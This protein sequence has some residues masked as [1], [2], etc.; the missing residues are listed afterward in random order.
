MNYAD[1]DTPFTRIHEPKHLHLERPWNRK[2]TVIM[3]EYSCV[4]PERPYYPV[5]FSSDREIYDKYAE[6]QREQPNVIFGGRLARYKYYDMHQVI[7]GALA[8][9]RKELSGVNESVYP[10]RHHEISNLCSL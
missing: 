4:D 3:R 10:A 2:S 7:A 8:E 6:L 5:N 1:E 9:A